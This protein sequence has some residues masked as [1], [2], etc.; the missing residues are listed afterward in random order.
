MNKTTQRIAAIV[1]AAG[2]TGALA[3]CTD[4]TVPETDPPITQPEQPT[5]PTD[6]TDDGTDDGMTEITETDAETVATAEYG[7]TVVGVESDDHN[8]EA[9]WKVELAGSSQGDIEVEV[10]KASGEIV[11]VDEE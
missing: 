6:T 10:S 11:A 9:T 5:E 7:G 2:L 4:N 3:A 8:G 1:L